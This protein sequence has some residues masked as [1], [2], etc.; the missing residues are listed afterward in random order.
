MY[1]RLD[2]IKK[3][4][5]KQKISLDFEKIKMGIQEVDDAVLKLGSTQKARPNLATKEVVLK[6]IADKDVTKLRE[7]SE[8]FCAVSGIYSRI[9]RYMANMYR[10]DWYVTPYVLDDKVDQKKLVTKFQESL[11]YFDNFNVKRHFGDIAFKVLREG[12]YYGYKVPMKNSLGIQELDPNYCRSRILDKDWNPVIEFNMRYFDDKF[13]DVQERMKILKIFPKEF[14]KGYM[15]YKKQSAPDILGKKANGWYVLDPACTVK[16]SATDNDIPLFISVIPMLID[17]DEAQGINRKRMLQELLK[18]VVQKLPLDK[19][20]EMIFD[21]EEIQQFHN[22]AVYM[23]SKAINVNV[24]TTLA[25]VEVEDLASD[26]SV[27]NDDLET[28]ER[29]VYNESGI[30]QLMFNST[31]NIALTMS[32][33]N[34]ESTMYNLILQ[35]QDFLNGTIKAFD[36][37]NKVNFGIQILLTTW[38]N[39]KDMA[40]AYKEQ[41]QLGFSKML[42]A[43]ALGQS[44]S[45]ILATAYF[46]NDVLNLVTKFIPPLSS[47]VMN[48]EVLATQGP[49]GLGTAATGGKGI[50][51]EK[52]DTTKESGNS[53]AAAP[54]EQPTGEGAGRPEKPDNEKST[55]TLQNIESQS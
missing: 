8:Y 18:I 3:E 10:Y 33:L 53:P 48:A 37:K 21:E 45:S 43:I 26:R 36:I 19:N 22:N 2:E 55:K 44:Q 7:I 32:E 29:Q 30:S 49:N 15:A 13:P 34:D 40:K 5:I 9:L 6:A 27:Q 20:G 31:G 25:D 47:N 16:F 41:T 23:L 1:N 54:K 38:Y 4:A 42:P 52:Q 39:Y 12:V 17:L 50:K 51:I 24:L 35:F 46:E 11:R 14:A 28:V